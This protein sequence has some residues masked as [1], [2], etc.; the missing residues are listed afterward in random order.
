[1][2]MKMLASIT[3]GTVNTLFKVDPEKV[4]LAHM[5]KNKEV[6]N[7]RTN[8]QEVQKPLSGDGS[9]V[10]RS[11]LGNNP[12]VIKADGYGQSNYTS[13]GTSY[14][15]S[16]EKKVGRNE[17]CPCGSGKKYKNKKS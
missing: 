1:M 11:T 5:L 4:L 7:M 9:T 16:P 2:F 6:K 13:S 14:G 10:T 3:T 8:E 15:S 12:V 17:P